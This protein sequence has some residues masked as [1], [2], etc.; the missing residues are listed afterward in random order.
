MI[1]AL[2]S[3]AK[4]LLI[5]LYDENSD[6]M[7]ALSDSEGG[8]TQSLSIAPDQSR[9]ATVFEKLETAV[10]LFITRLRTR[11]SDKSVNCFSFLCAYFK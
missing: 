1:R 2:L 9:A 6:K 5:R 4:R 10:G 11:L 7:F 8:V 3:A